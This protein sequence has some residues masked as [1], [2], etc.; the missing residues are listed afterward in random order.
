MTDAEKSELDGMY[1]ILTQLREKYIHAAKREEGVE[2]ENS[3]QNPTNSRY[4][5]GWQSAISAVAHLYGETEAVYYLRGRARE[6]K[7]Q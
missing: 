6:R 5:D 7:D 1:A 3:F 4:L 2:V